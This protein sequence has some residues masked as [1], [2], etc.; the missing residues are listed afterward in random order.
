MST[1]RWFGALG[2]TTIVLAAAAC[3]NGS[4]S[5]AGPNVV[6][7][8]GARLVAAT[9]DATTKAK[10]AKLTLNATIYGGAITKNLSIDMDGAIAFDG[11]AADFTMDLSSILPNAPSGARIEA[12]LV[13][14]VMYMDMGSM[15]RAIGG[16]AGGSLPSGLGDL[17][18]VKLDMH[19]ATGGATSSPSQYTQ[20]LEYL[21]GASGGKVDT[22]G[23]EQVRG[24]DTTHYHAEIPW[25]TVVK[26]A[27]ENLDKASP[28]LRAS[29]QKSLDL[30]QSTRD[31]VVADV[32]IDADGLTRRLEMR[33]PFNIAATLGNVT[34]K[35]TMELYDFGTPLNVE[36]PP[37]SQVTDLSQ[38][39]GLG[40]GTSA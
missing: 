20:Y 26:K 13:D 7:R 30:M 2:L 8:N 38:F 31:P 3:G 34:M 39:A 1:R 33:M 9:A 18:W 25:E 40:G 24:V 14:G 19:G 4:S 35:M 21:R 11:S 37:A 15:M 17:H 29:L 12:R 16:Q 10:T 28:E 22:I 36:A 32:W 6:V 5:S 27:E 23:H